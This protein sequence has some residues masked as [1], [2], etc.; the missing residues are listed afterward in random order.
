MVAV[1]C[2][3]IDCISVYVCTLCYCRR[4]NI[5]CYTVVNFVIVDCITILCC[6]RMY[7]GRWD[8]LLYYRDVLLLCGMFN[9]CRSTASCV[10]MIYVT[11]DCLL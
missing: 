3:T 9:Y 1:G 2:I 10:I 5:H 8:T 7:Y 6:C 4:Y 11:V